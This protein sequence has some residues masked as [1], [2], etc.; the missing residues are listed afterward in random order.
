MIEIFGDKYEKGDSRNI[1]KTGENVSILPGDSGSPLLVAGKGIVGVA[2]SIIVYK[3]QQTCFMLIY[4]LR[5]IVIF[6]E[7][8]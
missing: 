4:F 3:S 5:I 1:G 8:H 2:E 7:K 6:F